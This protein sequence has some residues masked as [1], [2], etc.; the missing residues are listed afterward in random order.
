M[1]HKSQ[2]LLLN[3]FYHVSE[4]APPWAHIQPA[5]YE[6]V[7]APFK[8]G[9]YLKKKKMESEITLGKNRHTIFFFLVVVTPMNL[10]HKKAPFTPGI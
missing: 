3:S 7:F 5:T 4:R 2:W 8:L 10:E 9:L 6:Y 1:K